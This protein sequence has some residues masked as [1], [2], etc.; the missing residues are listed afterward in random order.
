MRLILLLFCLAVSACAAQQHAAQYSYRPDRSSVGAEISDDGNFI[1]RAS[2]SSKNDLDL[3]RQ[4]AIRRLQ[5]AAL[6]NG[7][8]YYKLEQMSVHETPR[9]QI[10]LTGRLYRSGQ[11][12]VG[13]M[14]VTG[15]TSGVVAVANAGLIPD[16]GPIQL[17]NMRLDGGTVTSAVAKDD[18]LP[19]VVEAPE[20]I[21]E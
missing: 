4:A 14:L 8:E 20:F 11:N 21:V 2:V 5:E 13:A 6:M 3:A 17:S 10:V 16:D 12:P 7:Y 18:V 19:L 1:A 15:I 9:P